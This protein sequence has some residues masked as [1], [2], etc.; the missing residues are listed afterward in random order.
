MALCP[1]CLQVFPASSRLFP[2]VSSRVCSFS[3]FF[4]ILVSSLSAL[5]ARSLSLPVSR[6]S[7]VRETLRVTSTRL[8]SSLYIF[9]GEGR[10]PR[11]FRE[12]PS[13]QTQRCRRL[14][15]PWEA[16]RGS[17]RRPSLLRP[18]LRVSSRLPSRLECLWR[19]LRFFR[20]SASRVTSRST[21]SR[22]PSRRLSRN[23]GRNSWSGIRRWKRQPC[24]RCRRNS[25]RTSTC[26]WTQLHGAHCFL[27]LLSAPKTRKQ[28]S[29]PS[30]SSTRNAS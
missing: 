28:S 30:F 29:S 23:I 7:R 4:S 25:S 14:L 27:R 21:P 8:P 13:T 3:P 5:P 1:S 9:R 15:R 17:Q 20:S 22:R 19:C 11:R 6:L 2:P 16:L 12:P 26:S 24:R 10:L 18:Q